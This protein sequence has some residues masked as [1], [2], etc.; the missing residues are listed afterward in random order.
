MGKD[1]NVSLPFANVTAVLPQVKSTEV[2]VLIHHVLSVLA[3]PLDK[4]PNIIVWD[5][6]QITII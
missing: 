6:Q 5:Y 1:T 2:L 3:M 4:G